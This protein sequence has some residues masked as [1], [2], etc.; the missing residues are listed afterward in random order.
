MA[1]GI[2]LQELE[3]LI[4]PVV[5]GWINSGIANAKI[6][7]LTINY[8]PSP[9]TADDTTLPNNLAY[10]NISQSFIV[11]QHINAT[12][13]DATGAT[14]AALAATMFAAPTGADTGIKIGISANAA[15]VSGGVN[16]TTSVWGINSYGLHYGTGLV[17]TLAGIVATAENY[18]TGNV[19]IA[20][21]V[22][23]Q[24]HSRAAGVITDA[25]A[26]WAQAPNMVA[27][28]ATNSFG[29]YISNQ[30]A[31][32]IT[33]AKGIHIAA[34][35]G[36]TTNYAIYSAGGDI[37]LN[38]TST[39]TSGVGIAVYDIYTVTP[40]G[41]SSA[42][43]DAIQGIT[44]SSGTQ[45]ITGSVR[46]VTG[47]ARSDGS[48][49]I[50]TLLGVYGL[51]NNNSTGTTTSAYGVYGQYRMANAGGTTTSAYAV[52]AAAV[53][54]SS[55][56]LT[57][58]AQIAIVPPG[59]GTN[60]TNLLIGTATIPSGT[61]SIYNASA[62]ANY[63]AGRFVLAEITIPS[64]P[65]ADQLAVYAK[66]NGSGVTKLYTLDSASTET[67]LGAGTG[68]THP[69]VMARVGLR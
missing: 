64:A 61:Y 54:G 67:E 45:S 55:G 19:T 17:G 13:T 62:E 41:A 36:A 47:V 59:Q 56:T 1:S 37:Q 42:T 9:V 39:A 6:S 15:T 66:D 40:S 7:G 20:V 53:S 34:Q 31:S 22:S 69:Q 16:N 12:I 30:G 68:L 35:S 3:N 18:S 23:G 57:S 50:T 24:V 11:R 25:T 10:T 48:G 51:A 21:A 46:G 2:E 14:Q 5:M 26:L 8:V 44:I 52:M 33:T 60:R 65:A 38:N 29:L 4:K 32:G 58:I 63:F 27:G 28:T 49:T 43:F